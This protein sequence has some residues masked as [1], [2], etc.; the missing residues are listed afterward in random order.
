MLGRELVCV[1]VEEGGEQRHRIPLP[2]TSAEIA[3]GSSVFVSR[4][5]FTRTCPPA[6]PATETEERRR[7]SNLP[8][9][10]S[11]VTGLYQREGRGE[12]VRHGDIKL[13]PRPAQFR[14][15]GRC[16]Q[17]GSSGDRVSL[18]AFH[19][20][21]SGSIPGQATPGISQVGIVPDDAAGRR[22]FSAISRLPCTCIPTLLHSHLISPPSALKSPP[23]FSTQPMH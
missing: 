15:S 22:V 3:D 12:A 9:A 7:K 14:R 18:I 23:K 2:L 1:G 17:N 11:Q 6:K 13:M 16:T 10:A 8:L 5:S 20:N 4:G 19:S 21:E